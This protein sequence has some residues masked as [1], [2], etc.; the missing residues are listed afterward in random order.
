MGLIVV[1]VSYRLS[2]SLR[3]QMVVVVVVVMMAVAII[4]VVLFVAVIPA[5]AHTT[6]DN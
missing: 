1:L 5:M 6:S 4:E 2:T 3:A